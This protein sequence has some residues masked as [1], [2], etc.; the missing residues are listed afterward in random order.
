M[1]ERLALLA[2]CLSNTEKRRGGAGSSPSSEDSDEESALQ[3][4]KLKWSPVRVSVSREGPMSF[5]ERGGV[6]KV[7]WSAQTAV[8]SKLGRVLNL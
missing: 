1:S 6:L 5:P 3:N 2:V 4:H 8:E 7:I